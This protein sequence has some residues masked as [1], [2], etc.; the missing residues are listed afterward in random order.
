MGNGISSRAVIRKGALTTIQECTL[1]GH[2]IT[3]I[4]E[5]KEICIPKAVEQ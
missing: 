3:M 1:A 4:S 5:D 2:L